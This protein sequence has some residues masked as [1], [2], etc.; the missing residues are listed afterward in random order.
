MALVLV[1]IALGLALVAAAV[2][3][4]LAVRAGLEFRHELRRFRLAVVLKLEGVA[5][6]TEVLVAASATASTAPQRLEPS[7]GRLRTSLAELAVLTSAVQ[8]VRDAV[9]RVTAIY[10]R[11]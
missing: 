5:D 3:I 9:D 11:K 10:P 6:R 1:W 7:V 8:D 4:F 2:G